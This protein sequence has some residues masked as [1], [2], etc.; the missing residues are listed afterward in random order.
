MKK[1]TT[2]ALAG[3]V[4]TSVFGQQNAPV[5]QKYVASPEQLNATAFNVKNMMI[6]HDVEQ[7]SMV[8]ATSLPTG[9]VVSPNGKVSAVSPVTIGTAGNVFTVLRCEQN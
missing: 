3:L 1:F 5:K 9:P 2:L 8:R 6:F 4:A 7:Q